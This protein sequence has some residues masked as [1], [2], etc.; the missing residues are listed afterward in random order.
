[1]TRDNR[2]SFSI[3]SFFLGG[4]GEKGAGFFRSY[5]PMCVCNDMNYKFIHGTT[6]AA[7][8]RTIQSLFVQK[9]CWY[10]SVQWPNPFS[11]AN[12]MKV[13]VVLSHF[14]KCVDLRIKVRI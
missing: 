1:M 11:E 5:Q 3:V 6:G 2:F 14:T 8:T 4:G 7:D 13:Y 12:N 9:S 10:T